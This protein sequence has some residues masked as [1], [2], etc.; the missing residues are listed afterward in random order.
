M[1]RVD[2]CW[3]FAGLA[4]LLL[5]MAGP[6]AAQ[7]QTG[8]LY[9]TVIGEDGAPLPGVTVTVEGVGS[10][11]VLVTDERGEF[12]ALGLYPGTY[13]V[14]AELQGHSSLE[15]PDIGVRVGGKTTIEITLSSA[16][17]DVITVTGEAPLLDERK[18]NTGAN[19]PA[20]A[21]DK[22]FEP[23]VRGEVRPSKQGLGLGL[24]IAAQIAEAHAG[25]INVVST[26]EETRFT[27]RM[28]IA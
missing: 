8:D 27:L 13:K 3:F 5:W 23:F 7:L 21:L 24:Y 19:I 22:L 1:S 12:R 20:E 17:E 28:P 18:L 4:V 11:K 14:T 26:V 2:R 10:P 9:G 25:R 15:Y 16:V 6:A